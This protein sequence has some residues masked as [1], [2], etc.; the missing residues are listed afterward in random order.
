MHTSNG[1]VGRRRVPGG[2]SAGNHSRG[3]GQERKRLVIEPY[4][5]GQ[6]HGALDRADTDAPIVIAADCPDKALPMSK[7]NQVSQLRQS[8]LL[9]DKIAA[10]QKQI[11]VR[12]C[13]DP[14]QLLAKVFGFEFPKM[15]IAHI[16]HAKRT[17]YIRETDPLAA[18]IG[19]RVRSDLNLPGKSH[20]FSV[21]RWFNIAD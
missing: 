8:A 20:L 7:Q 15:Q 2:G 12:G 3:A 18:D 9:V 21:F 4:A 19:R 5:A 11:G 6:F 16:K 10:Q 13:D 1:D 14:L 17:V